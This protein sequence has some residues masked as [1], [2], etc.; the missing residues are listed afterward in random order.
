MV[1]YI[2]HGYNIYQLFPDDNGNF[3]T[4]SEKLNAKIEII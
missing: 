2:I 3:I 4:A 1:T